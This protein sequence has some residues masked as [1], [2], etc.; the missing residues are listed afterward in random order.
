[1]TSHDHSLY[2]LANASS[3]ICQKKKKKSTF[4]LLLEGGT[5][6]GV[7]FLEEK[8]SSHAGKERKSK[9]CCSA[10]TELIGSRV[11]HVASSSA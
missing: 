7:E 8:A 4:F 3:T 2:R 9:L 5:T 10:T 6:L 11:K 1:M